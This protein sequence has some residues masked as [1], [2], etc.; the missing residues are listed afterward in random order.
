MPYVTRRAPSPRHLSRLAVAVAGLAVLGIGWKLT[1]GDPAA[2][3]PAAIDAAPADYVPE[4]ASPGPPP[5]T[6]DPLGALE[7]PLPMGRPSTFGPSAPLGFLRV[8]SSYGPRR[9]PILGFTRM[10]QG[11]DFAAREGAPVLAAADGF[12]TEAGVEGGYGNLIRI[13]HAGGW[14]TGYAHLSGFARGV[15]DGARVTRGQVI[16]FVGHTGLATG[17]HLHFE[18]SLGGVKLDP[19]TTPFGGAPAA[20]PHAGAYARLRPAIAT[21]LPG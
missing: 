21:D 16:G 8:T 3:S 13:R 6:I 9:H 18:V 17:P 1:S 20:D 2:A 5:P 12:V 4:D 7:D 10:H 19:M 11:V 14:G 15:A